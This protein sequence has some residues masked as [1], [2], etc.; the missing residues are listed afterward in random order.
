[1]PFNALVTTCRTDFY[2]CLDSVRFSNTS[3]RI[4][5]FWFEFLNYF[6]KLFVVYL[7]D[8]WAVLKLISIF[9][10][11][12]HFIK[13]TGNNQLLSNYSCTSRDRSLDVA[14]SADLEVSDGV[15]QV[16]GGERKERQQRRTNDLRTALHYCPRTVNLLLLSP[17]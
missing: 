16:I 7:V 5:Y 12:E 6:L 1:M 17:V 4:W 14:E 8:L 2:F 15:S 9:G 10:L 11:P 3:V 13:L